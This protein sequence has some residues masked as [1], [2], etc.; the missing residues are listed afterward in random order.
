VDFLLVE[1]RH[2][3]AS[4]VAFKGGEVCL[5][6]LNKLRDAALIVVAARVGDEEVVGHGKRWP[7]AKDLL[8][9]K[10]KPAAVFELLIAPAR[11]AVITANFCAGIS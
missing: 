10:I 6:T 2:E 4:V 5:N 3:F 11:A 1:E 8:R 9:A 7:E